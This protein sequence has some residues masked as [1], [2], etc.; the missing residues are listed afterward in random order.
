MRMMMRYVVTSVEARYT[1]L[2]VKHHKV[3]F[4]LAIQFAM[5]R[6]PPLRLSEGGS[7]S[8]IFTMVQ[9]HSMSSVVKLYYMGRTAEDFTRSAEPNGI[10]RKYTC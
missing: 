4:Q 10:Q 7:E 6:V 2:E 3:V 9:L 5:G 8:T 1:L